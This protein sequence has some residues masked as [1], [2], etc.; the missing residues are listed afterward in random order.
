MKNLESKMGSKHREALENIPFSIYKEI[1]YLSISFSRL[2]AI[3]RKF[4][5]RNI[6]FA[7]ARVRAKDQEIK[8]LKKRVAE[9]E[10]AANKDLCVL[11]LVKANTTTTKE[12]GDRGAAW[13]DEKE[14]EEDQEDE[15][16]DEKTKEDEDKKEEEKEKAEKDE[17]KEKKTEEGQDDKKDQVSC[18]YEVEMNKN[19]EAISRKLN[20]GQDVDFG[21]RDYEAVHTLSSFIDDVQN[22][23]EFIRKRKPEA[24]DSALST[25]PA[26]RAKQRNKKRDYDQKEKD[27]A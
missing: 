27:H 21:E 6:S 14:E 7:F 8:N 24:F 15:K 10:A 20:F 11:A 5:E 1:P 13:K 18:Y 26:K 9:L 22:R 3:I 12:Q 2:P 19:L 17:Q 16:M 23:D 25:M 4:Q